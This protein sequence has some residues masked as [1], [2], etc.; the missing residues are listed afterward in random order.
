MVSTVHS[1]D[2]IISVLGGSS[3]GTPALIEALGKAYIMGEISPLQVRL[4]GRNSKR[5]SSIKEHANYVLAQLAGSVDPTQTGIKVSS[6]TCL[7]DAVIGSNIILCQVRVGGMQARAID[8]MLPLEFGIPGDEGLGP[9]GLACFLRSRQVISEL[10]AQCK[11]FASDALFL[12]MS[13]PLGLLT[14]TAADTFGPA[15]YGICELPA[16]TI[17]RVTDAVRSS[18]GLAIEDVL[19]YGLNH[20]GWLHAFRDTAGTNVT[21]QV[22]AAINSTSLL[23]IDS[24][25]IRKEGAVPLPYMRLYYHTVREVKRQ[26]SQAKS[27]GAELT[28]WI[29][30]VDDELLT[31][32]QLNHKKI[33]A[34][35]SQRNMQWYEYGI[36]PAICAFLGNTDRVISLNKTEVT[37]SEFHGAVVEVPCQVRGAEVTQ[38]KVPPLPES[39]HRLMAQLVRFEN[40][41]LALAEHPEPCDIAAVL[42][43]HPLV[44]DENIADRL[45]SK[46]WKHVFAPTHANN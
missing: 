11:E 14:S 4:Y 25:I 16:V 45:G 41:A 2:N 6:H 24:D 44:S 38:L 29:D 20:Q 31:P 13:S 27:R 33:A 5:M 10:A 3:T 7:S 15:C 23:G 8:E 34:L 9:S 21:D 18:I 35:L 43:G 12:M 26:K 28:Q 37:D 17:K 30:R 32:S 19:F 40:N 1:Q 42:V 39:P 46:V 36:V 22:L